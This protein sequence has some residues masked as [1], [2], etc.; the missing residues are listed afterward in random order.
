[1]K[2]TVCVTLFKALSESEAREFGNYLTTSYQKSGSVYKLYRHLRRYHPDLTNERLERKSVERRLFKEKADPERTLFDST[3]RLTAKLKSFITIKELEKQEVYENFLYLEALKS[4]KLD[5]LFFKKADS[6]QKKW[7]DDSIPGIEHFH[8]QYKLKILIFSHPNI[9]NLKSMVEVDNIIKLLNQYFATSKMYYTLI[10]QINDKDKNSS[11]YKISELINNFNK[12][13]FI[14]NTKVNLIYNFLLAYQSN[15]IS[16]YNKVKSSFFEFFHLFTKSEKH[17]MVDF[18]NDFFYSKRNEVDVNI[19]LFEIVKFALREDLLLEDG[20]MSSQSFLN[21]ISIA[22]VNGSIDWIETFIRDYK[23]NL[24]KKNRTNL[25][26]FGEIIL[27]IEKKDYSS[28][29]DKI[30]F[31][32]FKEPS[33]VA[34]LNCCKLQCFYQLKY[35]TSFLNAISSTQQYLSNHKIDLN[36]HF[37]FFKNFVKV[38]K[39]IY[40]LSVDLKLNQ[41]EGNLEYNETIEKLIKPNRPLYEEKWLSLKIKEIINKHF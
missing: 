15:N 22:K 25:V 19:Q 27:L 40:K 8:N 21:C 32:N 28:A 6:L 20:F 2:N 29:L 33:R 3:S 35:E 11:K 18:L 23:T 7:D 17:D 34:H 14:N 41:H 13:I 38:V 1:M 36:N 37:I 30:I 5:D 16:F 10:A 12:A 9:S 26:K 4:R 24:N 31:V 39:D